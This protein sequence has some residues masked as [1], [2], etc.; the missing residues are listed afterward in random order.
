M[1]RTSNRSRSLREPPSCPESNQLIDRHFKRVIRY[2]RPSDYVHGTVAAAAGPGLFYLME[3]MHPS[4]VGKGGFAQGLRLASF[5]GAV[6]GFYYFYQ[7]SICMFSR[8]T[9][10]RWRPTDRAVVTIDEGW[11]Y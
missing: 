4:G 10:L 11:L 8:P 2:A 7:R 3:R 9:P 1:T 5:I 6:G